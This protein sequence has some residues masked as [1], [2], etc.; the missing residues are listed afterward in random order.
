MRKN[1][2]NTGSYCK[3]L[4]F[5][6]DVRDASETSVACYFLSVKRFNAYSENLTTR[7]DKVHIHDPRLDGTKQ[8]IVLLVSFAYSFI[9][10]YQPTQFRT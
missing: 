9:M 1:F 3:V 5:I 6:N 10:I 8:E 7:G 4:A 2:R